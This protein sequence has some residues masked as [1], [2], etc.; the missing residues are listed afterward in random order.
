MVLKVHFEEFSDDS[1]KWHKSVT[2][3]EMTKYPVPGQ[4][5]CG[6][7]RFRDRSGSQAWNE[8]FFLF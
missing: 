3:D 5:S 7:L 4:S 8:E 2:I 1:D 6:S